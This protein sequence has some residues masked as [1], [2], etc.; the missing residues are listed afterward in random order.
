M[1]VAFNPPILNLWC[2]PFTCSPLWVTALCPWPPSTRSS[3]AGVAPSTRTSTTSSCPPPSRWSSFSPWRSCWAAWP[4]SCPAWPC[5]SGKSAAAGRRAATSASLCRRTAVATGWKMS[6][7]CEVNKLID[8][9]F[10]RKKCVKVKLYMLTLDNVN[11]SAN[12]C[13]VISSYIHC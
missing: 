1:A 4:S 2:P 8:V 3:L 12:I 5:G 11:M 9:K 7:K 10:Q 13:T 6:V